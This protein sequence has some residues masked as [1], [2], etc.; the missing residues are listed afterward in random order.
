MK[1]IADT[2]DI[3]RY[4]R[5]KIKEQNVIKNISTDSRSLKKD[6]L[7]IALRGI[8]FNGNDYVE[9]ALEKGAVIVITDDKRFKK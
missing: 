3:E 1:F 5:V 7:F 8:N 6:S 9:D 2:R 4:L